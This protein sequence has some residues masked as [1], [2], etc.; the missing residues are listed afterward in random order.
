MHCGLSHKLWEKG[1][2]TASWVALA[3][4]HVAMKKGKIT[5]SIKHKNRMETAVMTNSYDWALEMCVALVVPVF[6]W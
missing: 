1:T 2:G 4:N 6:V 3:T 5:D